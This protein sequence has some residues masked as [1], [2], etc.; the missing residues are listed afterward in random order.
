MYDTIRLYGYC[1]YYLA[2]IVNNSYNISD[3]NM[4]G[5]AYRM[6]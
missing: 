2:V 6:V 1:C 3:D 5:T 4:K